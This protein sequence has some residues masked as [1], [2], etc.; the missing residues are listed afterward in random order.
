MQSR[1]AAIFGSEG[2]SPIIRSATYTRLLQKDTIAIPVKAPAAVV[3][4]LPHEIRKKVFGFFGKQRLTN[5]IA[6]NNE[7]RGDN[8]GQ[9]TSPSTHVRSLKLFQA[10]Q[11]Q[12]D[13]FTKG[14]KGN[15]HG[16]AFAS[17]KAENRSNMGEVPR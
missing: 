13:C 8:R 4:L 12:P 2:S 6:G 5:A 3:G 15:T 17:T 1:A 10:A 11:R 9:T 7:L 16:Y 14:S